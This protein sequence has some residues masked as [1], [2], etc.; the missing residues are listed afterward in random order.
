MLI[1][2]IGVPLSMHERQLSFHEHEHGE[3]NKAYCHTVGSGGKSASDAT[4]VSIHS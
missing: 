4:R 3:V 2:T 1:S